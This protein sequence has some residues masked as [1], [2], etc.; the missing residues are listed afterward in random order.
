MDDVIEQI[1]V[2]N[3]DQVNQKGYQIP[4]EALHS[5]LVDSCLRS[6]LEGVQPFALYLNPNCAQLMGKALLPKSE[7]A[8]QDSSKQLTEDNDTSLINS[9]TPLTMSQKDGLHI[10]MSYHPLFKTKD[11]AS[12]LIDDFILTTEGNKRAISTYT[13]ELQ[14]L[15]KRKNLNLSLS[16][17]ASILEV[18]DLY[19]DFPCVHFN[20]PNSELI[21]TC[22][23]IFQIISQWAKDEKGNAVICFNLSYPIDSE[24]NIR[25]SIRGSVDSLTN[26]WNKKIFF[27]LVMDQVNPWLNAVQLSIK[28]ED[29]VV[30]NFSSLVKGTG[31]LV[32]NRKSLLPEIPFTPKWND[33][34]KFYDIQLQVSPETIELVSIAYK[35]G[36]TPVYLFKASDFICYN[37]SASFSKCLC[38]KILDGA[39]T[40][41]E[42]FEIIDAVWSD[43]AIYKL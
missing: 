8:K 2:I 24:K 37:C 14:K 28:N 12:L 43:L 7:I 13:Y 16:S 3:S 41:P 23:E 33:K 39:I 40:Y 34:T 27:P 31:S 15:F 21:E 1:I 38:S 29:S 42:N 19:W 30:K 18:M 4:I 32:I 6:P 9:L 5:D 35:I 22:S 10:V 11:E 26:F 17:E 20:N 36:L 25:F